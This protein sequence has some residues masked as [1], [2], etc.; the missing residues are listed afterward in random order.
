MNHAVDTRKSLL[1]R[2]GITYVPHQKLGVA[3]QSGR[4]AAIM[5]LFNQTIEESD[6]ITTPEEVEG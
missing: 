2:L 1:Q 6:A 3:R 4:A 5:Y